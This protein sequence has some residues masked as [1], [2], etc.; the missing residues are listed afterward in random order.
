[1]PR[2]GSPF[3]GVAVIALKEAAD[4]LS[5]VRVALIMLLI[6]LTGIGSVFVAFRE[7]SGKS[8]DDQFLFLRLLTT[9]KDPF[10]SFV[11]LLGFLLPLVAVTLAFD[12]INGEYARRTMSRVLSQPIYRDAVL[13]GKF[14]GGLV[15]LA[16]C[17]LTLWLMVTGLGIVMVGF[18]PGSEEVLRGL[19]FL[20]CA[21][22]YGGIWVAVA[23]M[24]STLFRAPATSALATLTLWLLFTVFWQII[25][26]VVAAVLAPVDPTDAMTEYN[27]ALATSF[28]SRL[29]PVT[30]YGEMTVALLTPEVRSLGVI[31]T[32]QL[33][34]AILGLP[35]PLTQSLLLIWS[36]LAASVAVMVVVFTLGY[37]AF[38]R[39]EVRA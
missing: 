27:N 10:P 4:H 14:L 24:F 35:L 11:G 9:G 33:E 15:V 20:G 34:G 28:V 26:P 1:M 19:T 31:F 18:P 21:L 13:V 8:Y 17:L 16:V 29:S 2:K 22:A 38:Q 37:V 3:S 6:A 5:S 32:S 36:H 39:Q 25:V 30:L 12:A 7:I 23:L